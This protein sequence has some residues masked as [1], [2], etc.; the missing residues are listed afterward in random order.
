[1]KEFNNDTLLISVLAHIEIEEL[2]I[3]SRFQNTY[4][5]K[6]DTIKTHKE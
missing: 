4:N 6:I 1:M 3:E 5:L 2:S